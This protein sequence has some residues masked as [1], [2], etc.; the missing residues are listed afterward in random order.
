MKINFPLLLTSTLLPLLLLAALAAPPPPPP[1]LPPWGCTE[2][3]VAFSP[4]L[5]YVS[6]PP[7]NLTDTVTQRCCDVIAKAMDTGYAYCFC[8]LIR[9]PTM[10]GFPL[11]QS[12]LLSLL[13][14]C[15]PLNETFLDDL[16]SLD[17]VCSGSPTLPPLRGTT[18]KIPPDSGLDAIPSASPS[19]SPTVS[20]QTS[21][22]PQ[23]FSQETDVVV[24]PL[25][26]ALPM[27]PEAALSMTP[28]AAVSDQSAARLCSN[29]N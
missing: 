19:A 28:E 6:A 22:P 15:P 2:E 16:I 13:S 7:N 29:T 27:T 1:P 10:L 3:V 20:P 12:R 25:P 4:C 26:L 8:Y 17:S 23:N 9:R 24:R 21:L 11:N 18:A 14:V 5:G